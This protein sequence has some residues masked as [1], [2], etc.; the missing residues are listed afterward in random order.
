MPESTKIWNGK[1]VHAGVFDFK[2]TYR[3]M[4]EWLR[5]H[6]YLVLEKKYT[7]KINARDIKFIEIRW[8]CYRKISD[9]FRFRMQLILKCPHVSSAEIQEGSLK[10]K[11]D[12][13]EI[14][15]RFDPGVFLDKDY[16]NRWGKNGVLNFFRNLYDKY[17]IRSRIIYYEDLLKDESDEFSNQIKAFL[18]LSGKV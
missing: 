18:V 12:K 3:F 16:E 14:E 2:E 4:Y 17:I 8:T 10:V 13:G 9:Y 5:A 1:V 15:I 11:R 7:E 6:D